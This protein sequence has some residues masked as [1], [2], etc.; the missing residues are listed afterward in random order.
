MR[1]CGSAAHPT[2]QWGIVKALD[3]EFVVPDWPVYALVPVMPTLALANPA[4]N[5]TLNRD[6]LALVNSQLRAA[7]RRYFFAMDFSACP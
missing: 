1:A 7:S 5:Q 6:G 4:V 2:A 3:G